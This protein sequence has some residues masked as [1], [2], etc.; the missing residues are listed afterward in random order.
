MGCCSK[1]QWESGG[2]KFTL[3]FKTP[4]VYNKHFGRATNSS[5]ETHSRCW[6]ARVKVT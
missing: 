5:L 3:A 2:K 1:G 4:E 6:C